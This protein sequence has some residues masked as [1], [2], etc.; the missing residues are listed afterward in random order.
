MCLC[1]LS[2]APQL[3]QAEPE[4]LTA[5]AAEPT[6]MTITVGT[7][8]DG[9]KIDVVG[10]SDF[11]RFNGNKG[12]VIVL[13]LYGNCDFW[14]DLC[15]V[16]DVYAPGS[17]TSFAKLGPGT[18]SKE[19]SL[20]SSGTY[21]IRV[22][23][24]KNNQTESYR[25]GLER[26]FP[27]S[28]NASPIDFGFDS[29]TQTIDPV[30]DQD[31]YTFFAYENSVVTL[32]LGNLRQGADGS[33]VAR[34]FGPDQTLVE[35][36]GPGGQSKDI[37]LPGEGIYTVRLLEDRNDQTATYNLNLQCLFPPS[38]HDTCGIP[39]TCNGLTPTLTGTDNNDVLVGTRGNDVI[40][41][42]GGNDRISGLGGNDVICGDS[43]QGGT[44]SDTL[45]GGGG[46]DQM[47]GNGGINI[48]YG[49]DGNDSLQGGNGRDSLFGGKG[50]DS[51]DGQGGDDALVGGAGNDVLKGGAGKNDV[52]DKQATDLVPPT[53]CEIIDKP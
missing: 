30:P 40:V 12:N 35:T 8:V 41:G 21:T 26:L 31:F 37:T 53:G 33:P 34:L 28:P 7:I 4:R 52:C 25:I 24:N 20:P 51:L 49:D 17:T 45:L 13:S 5:C 3:A 11:F 47:F 19:V 2:L 46:N 23:D 38:D 9:C 39:T 44:G 29:G 27:A 32:T 48:L 50:D 36:L 6:D 16:A 42:L 14:G 15:P 43:D 18:D 10:D 1:A 22:A